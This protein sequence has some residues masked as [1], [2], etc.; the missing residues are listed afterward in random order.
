MSRPAAVLLP[1]LLYLALALPLATRWSPPGDEGTTLDQVL[2]PPPLAADAGAA[3]PFASL[4]P[5]LGGEHARGAG[6]VLEAVRERGMH[7]PAYYLGVHLWTRAFGT[8]PFWLR[9]PGIVLGLLSVLGIWAVT[10]EILPEGSAPLWAATLLAASVTPLVFS[11]T[12]RPYGLELALIVAS[13]WLLF[14]LRRETLPR[15]EAACWA[16][17]VAVNLLGLY[18]LY[19]YAFFLAWQLAVLGLQALLAPRSSRAEEL[20]RVAGAGLLIGA[21]F[22][23]WLGPLS[24]HL[25]TT[26]TGRF[27]FQ[28]FPEA[29]TWLANAANLVRKLVLRGQFP[30]LGRLSP[31]AELALLTAAL[32]AWPLLHAGPPARRRDLRVFWLSLPLL[33]AGILLGDWL[34][35]THTVFLIKT[36]LPVIPLAIVALAVGAR[37][38]A[39]RRLGTACLVL[40]L[41]ILLA[42]SVDRVVEAFRARTW[43]QRVARSLGAHD[44]EGHVVVVS[45]RDRRF[46][47]PLLMS[48]RDAG[49]RQLALTWAGSPDL[50][51]VLLRLHGDPRVERISLVSFGD[52]EG[53]YPPARARTLTRARELGWHAVPN[54]IPSLDALERRPPGTGPGGGRRPPPWDGPEAA[55]SLIGPQPGG[56]TATTSTE[57]ST[58]WKPPPS[59]TPLTGLTSS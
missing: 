48:L 52:D 37:S 19:H 25:D 31:L 13:L 51:A 15:R 42:P 23:P 27:Y 40:W 30:E 8:V 59:V 38:L 28:G 16:G 36:M 21:G 2:G 44:G 24:D 3:R 7:P 11:L 39:S 29:G 47:Y 1:L 41:A 55:S 20:A 53:W 26:A 45:S 46:L 12:L 32:L 57:T 50:D 4:A 10:R 35:Q 58:V 33:P 54:G 34:R 56:A 22:A 18:T 6:E 17:F 43:Q 9:L 49:V 5:V 14:R